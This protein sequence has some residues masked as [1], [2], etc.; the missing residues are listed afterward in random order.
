[1]IMTVK[2]SYKEAGTCRNVSD[3]KTSKH[4]STSEQ[5]GQTA[6]ANDADMTNVQVS[7]PQSVQGQAR[8]E[9]LPTLA[10]DPVTARSRC[11][12][13]NRVLF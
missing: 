8:G 10:C 4:G 7:E 12:T 5:V 6:P 2:R 11:P 9:G 3:A 13:G 1:M